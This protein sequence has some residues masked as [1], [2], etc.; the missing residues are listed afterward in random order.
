[1][2]WP[3]NQQLHANIHECQP[4]F[5]CIR[6]K[7]TSQFALSTTSLTVTANLAKKA[8]FG[9]SVAPVVIHIQ[10][11]NARLK[12]AESPSKEGWHGGANC[13]FSLAFL[14]YTCT[15]S[16][17]LTVK[18]QVIKISFHLIMW[19][20]CVVLSHFLIQ[21]RYQF[22]MPWYTTTAHIV[23][24][25][26]V[27]FTPSPSFSPPDLISGYPDQL[28]ALEW[29]STGMGGKLPKNLYGINTPLQLSMWQNNLL[30]HRPKV[31]S[32][33]SQWHTA[34]FQNWVHCS[35][36]KILHV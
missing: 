28:L 20:K 29:V 26:N 35:R 7:P 30:T 3:C 31:C 21:S 19:F 9:M 33:H 22:S 17:L 13:S 4:F 18:C 23:W 15:C 32:I 16:H 24:D 36:T 11:V 8:A 5:S 12:A 34:R 25:R 10:E 14:Q 1:M 2:P 6:E 27:V